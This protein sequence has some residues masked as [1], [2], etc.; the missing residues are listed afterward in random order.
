MARS[1]EFIGAI[2]FSAPEM[3]DGERFTNKCDVWALG[4]V[5][6]FMIMRVPPV[7][8]IVLYY[9]FYSNIVTY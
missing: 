6:Y 1:R 4:C 7:M 5:L 2:Q 9:I 8:F 3:L